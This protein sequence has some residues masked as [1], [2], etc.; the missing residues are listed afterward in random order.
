MYAIVGPLV[1]LM[2]IIIAWAQYEDAKANEEQDQKFLEFA[3][4][5]AQ[6][7]NTNT[8]VS[9]IRSDLATLDR[10]NTKQLNKD[11]GKIV[12]TKKGDINKAFNDYNLRTAEIEAKRADNPLPAYPDCANKYLRDSNVDVPPSSN[13]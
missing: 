5:Q 7:N 12:A 9:K 3:Y 2:G 8:A 1:I 11:V 10:E 6:Y 13:E 4:C